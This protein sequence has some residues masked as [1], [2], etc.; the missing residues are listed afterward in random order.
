M[1]LDNIGVYSLIH[2]NA[3]GSENFLFSQGMETIKKCRPHD[4][5]CMFP[6]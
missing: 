5:C 2:C 4:W 6:L 1:N 3:Q